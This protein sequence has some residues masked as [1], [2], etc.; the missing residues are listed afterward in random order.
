M[1][2]D[3]D[4]REYDMVEMLDMVMANYLTSSDGDQAV[5]L[6]DSILRLERTVERNTRYLMQLLSTGASIR[7]PGDSKSTA[8]VRSTRDLDRSEK[9]KGQ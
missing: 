2:S 9:R 3:E 7:A 8:D 1:E 4:V 6:V 5:N